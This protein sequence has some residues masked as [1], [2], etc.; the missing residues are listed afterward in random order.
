MKLELRAKGVHM[1]DGLREFI[2]KKLRVALGR[3]SH[4]VQRVRVR[5]TD[6]NGPRGGEDIQCHI[7]AHLGR[8]GAVMID[9]TRGDAF[10]AVARASQRVS[11]YL[12]RHISRAH[13]ARRG[14]GA[15][16]RGGRA[17]HEVGSQG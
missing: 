3:F 13:R 4:R 12:S 11:Q 6:I 10:A 2:D 8:G 15:R 7:Q 14:R 17:G 5:L 9:E 1:T 16:L